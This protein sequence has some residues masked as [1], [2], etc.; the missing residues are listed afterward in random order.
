[1]CSCLRGWLAGWVEYEKNRGK[2]KKKEG[3]G[4]RQKETSKEDTGAKRQKT[5]AS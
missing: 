4:E 3:G 5:G 2:G 1:M